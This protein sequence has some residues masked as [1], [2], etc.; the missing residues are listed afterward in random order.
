MA[1]DIPS[2]PQITWRDA[3]NTATPVTS[4]RLA[5]R[6]A[7]IRAASTALN[8]GDVPDGFV[9]AL[10][11]P[12]TAL[13]SA[14]TSLAEAAVPTGV[15]P[16]VNAMSSLATPRPTGYTGPVMWLLPEGAGEPTAAL[17]GDIF[18]R[19]TA[20]A[21]SW[22]PAALPGLHTW[23]DAQAL[24]GISNGTAVPSLTDLSGSGHTM[25]AAGGANQALY[26]PTGIAG[27]P[28]LQFDGVD[29][30]YTTAVFSPAHSAPWSVYVVAQVGP[31]SVTASDCLFDGN[32]TGDIASRLGVY[33]PP[34]GTFSI[35]RG[36]SIVSGPTVPTS[37][38]FILRVKYDGANSSVNLNGVETPITLVDTTYNIV[39]LLLGDRAELGR[40]WE[41]HIGEAF[42]VA[43]AVSP[44]N[45]TAALSYLTARW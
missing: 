11:N 32:I 18:L 24:T 16:T 39:R 41:G 36:S 14:V 5:E 21:S 2:L 3:P 28:A 29:D 34:A 37:G 25:T 44:A 7:A 43:G 27:R 23:I 13:S 40:P 17:A 38:R 31:A 45:D 15:L 1:T 20:S 9:A 4:A 10:A 19:V 33:R 12:E 30:A 8:T 22:T 6:D 42:W 26:R 35:L